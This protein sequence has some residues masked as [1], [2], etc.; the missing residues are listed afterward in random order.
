MTNRV[1]LPGDEFRLPDRNI[2]GE[3][4]FLAFFSRYRDEFCIFGVAGVAEDESLLEFHAA[5]VRAQAQIIDHSQTSLLMLDHSKFGR[6]APAAGEN[7]VNVD[8]IIPDGLPDGDHALLVEN[9]RDKL[10]LT[11]GG[12]ST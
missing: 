5:E 10:I 3:S 7:I 4:V 8:Q 12:A 11:S 6:M 1:V 2:L 9:L